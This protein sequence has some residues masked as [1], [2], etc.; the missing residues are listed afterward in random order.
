LNKIIA[1]L[2]RGE[3][4]FGGAIISPGQIDSA[5]LFSEF[6]YD[7]S[8]INLEHDAFDLAN[9]RDTLQYMLDRRQIAESGVAPACVPLVRM[10]INARE[11]N[12]WI[13]KQVLDLGAYGVVV[14]MIETVEDARAAVAAC[15]YPRP[16]G[17]PASVIEGHRGFSRVAARYWGI[18]AQEYHD[19]A[20]PWPLNPDGEILVIAFVETLTGVKNLPDILREV[21]GIGAVCTGPGDMAISMGLGHLDPRDP[22]VL[23]HLEEAYAQIAAACRER[24]VACGIVVHDIKVLE[25]RLAQGFNIIISAPVISDPVLVEGRRMTGQAAGAPR[26]HA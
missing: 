7:F 2:E 11:N 20:D 13:F 3:V 6:G 17:A 19:F 1:R 10:P 8:E 18:G 9:L 26:G 14:P 21:P 22:Q 25:K 12:E 5:R 16:S 4:A 15:T 23:P 24:S